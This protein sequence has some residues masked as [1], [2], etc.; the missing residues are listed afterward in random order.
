MALRENMQLPESNRCA[1]RQDALH[2]QHQRCVPER[3][4]R[5]IKISREFRR[6][7]ARRRR[8]ELRFR[9]LIPNPRTYS[10]HEPHRIRLAAGELVITTLLNTMTRLVVQHV[11]RDHQVL[12]A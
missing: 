7:P 10:V 11:R 8:P 4:N 1:I 9:N 2:Q 6:Y 12:A 3:S 5:A